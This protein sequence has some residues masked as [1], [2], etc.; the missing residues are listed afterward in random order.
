MICEPHV[1]MSHVFS[2][3]QSSNQQAASSASAKRG[4]W[5]LLQANL[6]WWS[7]NGD[8]QIARNHCYASSWTA[9]MVNR[10]LFGKLVAAEKNCQSHLCTPNVR[11]GVQGHPEIHWPVHEFADFEH[12]GRDF[13]HLQLGWN[14]NVFSG[15]AVFFF[16]HWCKNLYKFK[17][18]LGIFCKEFN[19]MALLKQV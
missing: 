5:V 11:N 13:E 17:T 14:T 2:W 4:R 7:W 1:G 16:M 18:L 9:S 10:I 6:Y 15:E 8:P 19:N 12:R 3:E